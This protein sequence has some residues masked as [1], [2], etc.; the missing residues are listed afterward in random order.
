MRSAEG[1][2]NAADASD[3]GAG[4]GLSNDAIDEGRGDAGRSKSRLGSMGSNDGL[5][6]L[7]VAERREWSEFVRPSAF[8][9]PW[10][11]SRL[12]DHDP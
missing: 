8:V 6:W 2:P 7:N 1:Q 5:N 9:R 3:E 11:K 12:V 10:R 4:S